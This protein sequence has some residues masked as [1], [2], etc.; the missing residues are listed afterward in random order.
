MADDPAWLTARERGD[1]VSQ[2]PEAER[3][4][5]RA[6]EALIAELPAQSPG[7]GW[8]RRVLAALDQASEPTDVPAV[9]VPPRGA[10][11]AP[12]PTP[13]RAPARRTW[14][15]I[16]G[17]AVA[18]AAAITVFVERVRPEPAMRA[19]AVA[20]DVDVDV[21][22]A[23]I[24]HGSEPRRG[25]DAAM[26]DS[27]RLRVDTQA[28]AEIR[29]YGDTGEPLARC[30]DTEGCQVVRNGARRHYTLVLPLRTPGDVRAVLFNGA[31][32]L[33]PPRDLDTDLAIAAHAGIAA[34][35]I[36]TQRVQ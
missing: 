26:G 30:N 18:A 35:Q 13:P 2:I 14:V 22:E 27:L 5:Y 15:W 17:T 23:D 28:G 1:D 32:A 34:R 6:L 31:G 8:K 29:V 12:E 4:R 9:P 11:P 3:E 16:G 21:I 25:G 36:A 24:V 20:G 33:P 19:A 10:V 7:P